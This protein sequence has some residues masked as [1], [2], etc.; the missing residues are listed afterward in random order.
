MRLLFAD[1]VGR[2]IYW[3]VFALAFLAGI[4]GLSIN[5]VSAQVLLLPAVIVAILATGYLVRHW[6]D[7][8]RRRPDAF[9]KKRGIG[10]WL[11]IAL[12][13]CMFGFTYFSLFFVTLPA[14]TTDLFGVRYQSED[15]VLRV[16][17]CDGRRCSFC[18]KQLWLRDHDSLF[19]FCPNESDWSNLK[20]GEPVLVVGNASS[21]GTR[22]TSFAKANRTLP[23]SA[24]HSQV[25]GPLSLPE[26]N[27]HP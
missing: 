2:T 20:N 4:A 26:T 23:G 27:L 25:P 3:W 22:I 9:P 11:L 1:T 17:D 15:L 19:H 10:Y 12:A 24:P 14:I 13:F 21:L 6:F 7:L 5:F 16:E 18:R 8:L